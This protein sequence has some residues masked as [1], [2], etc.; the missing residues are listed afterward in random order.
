MKNT[1]ST[2]PKKL[3]PGRV[4]LWVPGSQAAQSFPVRL[5]DYAACPAWLV[6]KDAQTGQVRQVLREEIFDLQP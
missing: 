1:L 3:E 2:Y 4:Y 5:L 6:V